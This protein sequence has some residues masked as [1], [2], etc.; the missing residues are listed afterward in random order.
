MRTEDEIR[1]LKI[2]L[3]GY[4]RSYMKLGNMS[5]IDE[6]IIKIDILNWVLEV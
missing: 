5:R 4:K 2:I 1:D 3:E 6:C